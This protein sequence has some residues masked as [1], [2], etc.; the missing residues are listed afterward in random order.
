MAQFTI[1]VELHGATP[2]DYEKLHDSMSANGFQKTIESSGGIR[3]KLPEAEYVFSS[4]TL[5]TESVLDKAIAV[6]EKISI[7]P[8]VIVTKS[9]GRMWVGLK[10]SI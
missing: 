1:R 10:K 2:K 8:A 4:Q 3:Y 6:A 9:V 5:N 7:L